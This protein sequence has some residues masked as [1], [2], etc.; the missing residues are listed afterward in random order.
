MMVGVHTSWAAV[1]TFKEKMSVVKAVVAADEFLNEGSSPP[2][3][4]DLVFIPGSNTEALAVELA[5]ADA[6]VVRRTKVNDSLLRAGPRLRLVQ[7]VGIGVDGIDL[8]AAARQGIPVANT[9]QAVTTAVV[10]HVFL[11]LLAAARGFIH[12]NDRLRRGEWSS[13]EIWESLEIAGSTLGIIGFGSI[14]KGIA[15]RALT[16]EAAFLIHTRTL[17]ADPPRGVDFV[18]LERLLGESDAVVLAVPLTEK[19]RGLIGRRELG[20]MKPSSLFINVARGAVVDEDA[21][22]DALAAG[23]LRA[24]ALD[25]FA[26]E[27]L[28]PDSPLRRLPNVVATPHYGGASSASRRRLWQQIVDNLDRLAAGRELAN[29]VNRKG[30]S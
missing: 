21:L 14:G 6:L 13:L 8:A 27:P 28:P 30:H 20:L 3:L 15:Q 4:H 22:V 17:L 5:E 12:Q 16:F 25:V 1:L 7:Q 10:E 29:V 26:H 11:L 18:E 24:A 19:T 9:P 2:S 23:R